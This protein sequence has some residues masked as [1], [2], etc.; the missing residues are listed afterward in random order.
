MPHSL[1]AHVPET[2]PAESTPVQLTRMEGIL[3]VVLERT[4]TLTRRMD[5][6]EERARS[7]E[8]VTQR[9]DLDALSRDKTA[10][11]L[12]LALKEAKEAVEATARLKGAE[13]ANTWSP[14]ARFGAVLG[15]LVAIGSLYLQTR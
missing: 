2:H 8:A 11:A 10:V 14:F 3:N 4:S 5:E 13:E 15:S 9:L 6:V 7:L 12:A 1:M